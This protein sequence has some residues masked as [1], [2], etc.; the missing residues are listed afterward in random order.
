MKKIAIIGLGWLGMPLA[1]ALSQRG[2][3]VQGS[4]TSD[5]GILAAQRCGISAVKLVMTPD[6]DCDAEELA[7]LM[8]VETLI[9]TLPA[10]RSS[11]GGE[12]YVHSVQNLVDTAIAYGVKRVIFTSSTS[13]YGEQEG[14]V[15]EASPLLPVTPAGK[16]LVALEQWLHQLPG[17][18]VDILRLS[19]LVGPDR[20][21][22]R[23]LAGRTGLKNGHHPVNL[24]HLDDV[25]DAITLLLDT[26]VSGATYNLSATLHPRRDEFYPCVAKQLGLIPPTFEPIDTHAPSGKCVNGQAICR[27]LGFQYRYADPFTMPVG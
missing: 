9:I 21:P 7:Q 22:G 6:I 19:G 3:E 4:K 11:E 12:H 25:V 13:V 17:I 16:R 18:D 20:H 24:V 27:T 14:E 2:N 8:S 15:V 26:P 1:L 5:D 23:F 10:S